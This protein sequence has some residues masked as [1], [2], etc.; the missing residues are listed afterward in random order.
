M[1][2][3][4][5]SPPPGFSLSESRASTSPRPG[6]STSRGGPMRSPDGHVTRKRQPIRDASRDKEPPPANQSEM[7]HVT[8]N[9]RQL[10][11]NSWV[12]SRDNLNSD[13]S[14]GMAVSHNSGPMGGPSP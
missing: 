14:E 10:T 3:H 2:K 4:C 8:K 6:P 12:W 9:P 5:T 11:R 1:W 13:Q 7:R